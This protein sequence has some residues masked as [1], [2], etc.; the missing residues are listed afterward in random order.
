MAE[1]WQNMCGRV[2]KNLK[3]YMEILKEMHPIINSTCTTNKCATIITRYKAL[4]V[5]IV[6]FR[7]GNEIIV[8]E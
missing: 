2:M 7:W 3:G 8:R 1:Y 6:G 5:S 4:F